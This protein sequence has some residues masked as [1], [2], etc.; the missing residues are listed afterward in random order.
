MKQA[1]LKRFMLGY[2]SLIALILVFIIGAD[3]SG[4]SGVEE[5]IYILPC[6]VYAWCTQY[7]YMVE[8]NQ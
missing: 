1:C 4:V 8:N 6:F 7:F 3:K 2:A 5:F